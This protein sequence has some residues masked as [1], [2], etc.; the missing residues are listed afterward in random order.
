MST[1]GPAA[2]KEGGGSLSASE[3]ETLVSGYL[4]GTVDEATMTAFLR[5]GVREGFTEAEAIALTDA[6]VVTGEALDLTALGPEVVDKHSTGGVG[7]TTTLL[8]APLL[9]AAGARVVKLSGRGLAHTGGTIDKL[10]AIPGMRTDLSPDELVAVTREAGCVVAAQSRELVP[11]DKALYDLRDAVGAVAEP[12]LIA[13]S[14]MAKKLAGG[15]PT[16]VLDVKAGEGAFM[17]DVGEAAALAGLCVRIGQAKGRRMT[18]LVTAMDQPLGR[19]VGNAV[20]VAEAVNQLRSTPTGRLAEVA[21]ELAANGLAVARGEELDAARAEILDRWRDGSGLERLQAMVA[22][23]GGDPAV[24]TDPRR[25]LPQAPVT[26]AVTAPR[27]GVVGRVSA[28]GV[29]EATVALGARSDPSVGI[30]LA[31]EAGE[32]VEAGSELA[33]V[34]A[35]TEDDAA[36]VAGMLAEHIALAEE[37]VAPPTTILRRLTG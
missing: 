30:E 24:C 36:R 9:A 5:A 13:S 2:R 26:R 6:L 1:S 37:P 21:V 12:A 25:V 34:H 3:L 27:R 17:P 29:G 4:D 10:E 7:D 19:A 20:E 23:Q 15:A 28:R 14:V 32:R 18:A 35:G 11:G 31:V 22:A 33:L 16:I 8:V